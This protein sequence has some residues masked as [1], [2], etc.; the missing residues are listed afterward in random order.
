[1]ILSVCSS[2][3]LFCADKGIA[4]QYF[5]QA[6]ALYSSGKI[7]EAEKL[8][9]Y[10]YEFDPDSSETTFLLSL[11]LLQNQTTLLSG[12]DFLKKSIED[13]SWRDTNPLV[14]KRELG[15]V[16]LQIN[17]LQEAIRIFQSMGSWLQEDVL[18]AFYLA[19]TYKASLT[20]G[21]SFE[22][23]EQ[24]LSDS[25]KRFPGF[26]EFYILY[27][28]YL[29]QTGN[30]DAARD[31]IN[32]GLE[33]A[34]ENTGLLLA[35]IKLT[36]ESSDAAQLLSAYFEK[37]GNALEAYVLALSLS[38]DNPDYYLDMYLEHQGNKD[39]PLLD[40]IKTILHDKEEQ[41]QGFWEKVD[42]YSGT[43]IVDFNRDGFPEEIY[44]Y[45]E[46]ILYLWQRDYNQD[47]IPEIEIGFIN[48]FPSFVR[49]FAAEGQVIY[50]KYSTYP[51]IESF[52][53][54]NNEIGEEYLLLPLQY[55]YRVFQDPEPDPEKLQL[56]FRPS[57]SPPL[58]KDI[59]EIAFT[60]KERFNETLIAQYELLKGAYVSVS[61]DT[62]KNGTMD[63]FVHYNNGRI[64]KGKRDLDG[65]GYY[66]ITEFYENGNLTKITYHDPLRD[67]YPDCIQF[68]NAKGEIFET[69]WDY[70]GDGIIDAKEI[71]KDKTEVVFLFSTGYDAVFDLHIVFRDGKVVYSKR[72]NKIL[73]I[74]PGKRAGIYWI[75]KKG[76]DPGV[77]SFS[78]NGLYTSKGIIYFIFTYEDSIYI[79]ELN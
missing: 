56:P 66:E 48:S 51:Y 52:T 29:E 26:P 74:I 45:K 38:A 46:G 31:I 57:F 50:G 20:R 36:P 76:K 8:L 64:A 71:V 72:G 3:F 22:Q 35:K 61:K 17:M 54:L 75:G 12:L 6:Q 27:A 65:D 34:P 1:M 59:R 62:D 4:L 63:Y 16:Y 77:T 42:G 37:G 13:N 19:K 24:F 40:R 2:G 32:Q 68:F 44:H 70:N 49:F 60:L 21:I 55:T 5:K 41:F 58:Q 7:E 10:S 39:I 15:R 30:I 79:E 47:G 23:L 28:D 9:I 14:A 73:S 43:R 18:S 69:H 78:G 25:L 53:F 11:I 33:K 67:N